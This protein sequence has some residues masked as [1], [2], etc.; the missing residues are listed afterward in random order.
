MRKDKSNR[1]RDRIN[2]L[3]VSNDVSQNFYAYITNIV[4]TKIKLSDTL[5]L[6]V[7][8]DQYDRYREGGNYLVILKNTSEL[9]STCSPN[10]IVREI[11][12]C[13]RGLFG[14]GGIRF[15]RLF[16]FFK[17]YP[18]PVCMALPLDS[19]GPKNTETIV[20]Y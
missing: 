20:A 14:K 4:A 2:D 17:I 11:Q 3:I 6:G 19:A 7:F 9:F 16:D 18:F 5:H 1:W 10:M 12:V 8:K 13:D 15:L